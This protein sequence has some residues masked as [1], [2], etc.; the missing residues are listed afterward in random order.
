MPKSQKLFTVKVNESTFFALKDLKLTLE[1]RTKRTVTK[2]ALM[3][4]IV[5][6]FMSEG[7]IKKEE[8]KPEKIE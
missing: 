4:A 7:G 1:K 3:E 8:E 5:G 2:V 6:K